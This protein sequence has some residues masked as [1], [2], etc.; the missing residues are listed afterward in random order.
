M[1]RIHPRQYGTFIIHPARRDAVT[2][3]TR[4]E[5]H[6]FLGAPMH[7]ISRRE[8]V[9]LAA[10]GAAAVPFTHPQSPPA[11]GLTAQDVVDRIKRS[12]G[13]PWKDDTVDTFRAGDPS[14]TVKGIVTTSLPTMDVLR[15]ALDLGANL[16]ITSEPT[17]YSRADTPTPPAGRGGVAPSG[18]PAGGSSQDARNTTDPVFAAKVQF[19][20]KQTLVVWRFG[21]HWRLRRPDP[22]AQGLAD[23]LGW[24][25][26][27]GPDDPARVTI[28][29]SRLDALASR[30]ADRLN[31]RGGVRVLGAP[32]TQVQKVGLLPG[33]TPI[34]AA[35]KMLPD[36]DLIV[37][38]EVREWE[39]VEY[40]RDAVTA[41]QNK[42][43]ILTGR[44]LSTDPGMNA[45][46][47]WLG[48]IVPE[49]TTSW[50][51]AGDPYWRPL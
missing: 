36:V 48:T 40:A 45:C 34:S 8:F 31:A 49:V 47:K 43:L 16:I 4:T 38:G 15:R 46:A 2:L 17:F 44:V 25:G 24:S 22:L 6:V 12:V 39:T 23:A 26:H 33:T 9:A 7:R 18:A 5:E 13:V 35:L 29:A 42:A 10:T 30:I 3:A 21:D 32:E 1:N 37:A 28:P 41:G 19:L 11:A 51:P 50:I 20:Q 27:A 14:T